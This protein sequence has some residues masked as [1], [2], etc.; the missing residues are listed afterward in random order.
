V[1]RPAP[2]TPSSVRPRRASTRT[3]S[4]SCPEPASRSAYALVRHAGGAP[5]GETPD[6]DAGR[7]SGFLI[8]GESVDGSFSIPERIK[9]EKAGTYL[10]CLWLVD[11]NST[12]DAPTIAGAK[13]SFTYTVGKKR[14]SPCTS[15]KSRRAALTRKV[16]AT[17]KSLLRTGR[18]A[19]RRALAKR[20]RSEKRQLAAA[21]RRV[22]QVCH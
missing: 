15:A 9:Q 21:K 18:K 11:G 14:V 6:A 19:T 17:K 3:P 20:L 2:S 5:C 10:V 8:N 1:S 4:S 13:K 16:S 7:D 12:I 22:K